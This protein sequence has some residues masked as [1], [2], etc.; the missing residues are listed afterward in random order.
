MDV[1]F[2][3]RFGPDKSM[4]QSG[5][6]LMSVQTWFAIQNTERAYLSHPTEG[7]VT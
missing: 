6:S 1:A 2:W 7:A 4:V 5:L 3:K